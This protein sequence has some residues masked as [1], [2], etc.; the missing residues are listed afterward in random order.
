[1]DQAA[2]IRW[3]L[4]DARTVEERYT[5]ELLV[6]EMIGRWHDQHKTGH[7]E[8]WEARRDR[9][10]QR[11]LNPAYAPAYSAPDLSHAVEIWAEQKTWSLSPPY[12]TRP[13]RDLAALRFFTHLEEIKIGGSEITDLSPLLALPNLRLLEFNS[14]TCEDFR[15]LARATQLRSL[16]LG[17]QIH[18]PELAGLETLQQLESLV[19]SG[20]LLAL[21]PGLVWPRVR[22]GRLNCAPLAARS[23]A[24]L[25][26]F[27][28]CEFLQLGGVERLDGIAAFPR[29]RNLTV[30]GVVRDFAPLTVLDQ[31]TCFT[32]SGALPLDVTPLAR[33]P[34]LHFAAFATQHTFGLDTARPRDYMPLLDAPQLRELAVTGCLPV[35]PEVANLNRLFPK[36]D[37]LFLRP[38]PR[39]LPPLEFIVA[40]HLQHPRGPDTALEPEDN[41]LADAGL[42]ACEERW[43]ARFIERHVA[44]KLGNQ[45]EWGDVTA[46]GVSRTFFATLTCYTLVEKFP[47]IMD[48]LREAIARLRWDYVGGFMI[49][50]KVPPIEPTPAQVELEKQFR[51]RMDEEDFEHRQRE[52]REYLERLYRLDLKKQAGEKI[53]PEDFAVPP[54]EPF[55]PP[56]WESEDEEAEDEDGNHGEGGLAVMEKPEP[57]PDPWDNDH[58][59]ADKYRMIGSINLSEIWVTSHAR[60]LA[61]YLM[62]REPDR[63]IPEEKPPA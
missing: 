14:A 62:G 52:Q 10:R 44:T 6:E 8:G 50:L 58:P 26:G 25:P 34:R 53:N 19:L 57:P 13:V 47:L 18:W 46:Y 29:L 36:W 17:L 21:P 22:V 3:A 61:V 48:G 11:H 41:G 2:F 40:P 31:L 63:E 43:V 9:D 33:L 5:V 20:N 4:D 12:Q 51:A 24:D 30:N 49:A 45:P 35:E 16:S 42:R 38:E 56:P 37:D 1:M 27:P 54:P 59:L 7:H 28:A 60:D 32:H 15:P 55:S 39:P 23:V